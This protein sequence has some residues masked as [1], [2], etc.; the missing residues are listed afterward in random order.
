MT[1]SPDRESIFPSS[2]WQFLTGRYSFSLDSPLSVPEC[3]H[4]FRHHLR[5]EYEASWGLAF[6]LALTA[7]Y[8]DLDVDDARFCVELSSVPIPIIG[9]KATGHCYTTN[10]RTVIDFE[11]RTLPGNY[12]FV[13]IPAIFLLISFL[14]GLAFF[15]LG[16]LFF[17]GVLIYFLF[18]IRDYVDQQRKFCHSLLESI[19]NTLDDSC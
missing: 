13:F 11:V 18:A 19:R 4:Q 12:V 1:A 16:V 7:R 15:P 14:V 8:Q 9:A 3:L 5:F 2:K 17:W 6:G 10:E